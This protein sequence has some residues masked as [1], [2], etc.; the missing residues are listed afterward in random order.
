VDAPLMLDT[1]FDLATI[2]AAVWLALWYLKI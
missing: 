1:W 2:C